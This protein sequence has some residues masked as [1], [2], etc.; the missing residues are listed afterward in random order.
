M[1]FVALESG[2]EYLL[3]G[4]AAWHMDSVRRIAGKDAPWITEDQSAVMDQLQWLNALSRSEPRLVIVASH[5]E[6]ERARL[7]TAGT[8]GG[9]FEF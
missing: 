4:D 3:I 2:G 5:D 1:V 9:R 6:E 7:I 8:L